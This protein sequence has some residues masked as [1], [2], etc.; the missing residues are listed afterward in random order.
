MPK[1]PDFSESNVFTFTRPT[2]DPFDAAL[3]SNGSRIFGG[4]IT[5]AFA[6]PASLADP[7]LAIAAAPG[8]VVIT[9]NAPGMVLQQ[10]T[11]LTGSGPGGWVD[12]ASATSPYQVALPAAGP[13]R[14]F[15]LRP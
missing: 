9:W 8:G 1:F 13:R 15:R 3:T 12:L 6:P 2:S 10:S 5:Y 11:D 14:F 4:S 7:G